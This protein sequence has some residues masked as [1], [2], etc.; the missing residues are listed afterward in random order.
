[1]MSRDKLCSYGDI[2]ETDNMAF[3]ELTKIH[4][5]IVHL[6]QTKYP[7]YEESPQNILINSL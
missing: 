6:S 3:R 7:I 4:I 1:M 5:N 2:N